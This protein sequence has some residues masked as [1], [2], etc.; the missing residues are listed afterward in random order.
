MLSLL[1]NASY[2]AGVSLQTRVVFISLTGPQILFHST[3][4]EYILTTLPWLIGSIGTM[5]EDATIFV[6]FHIYGDKSALEDT[7]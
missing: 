7:E 1:G 5:A 6:Q 4:R 2:G 3:E